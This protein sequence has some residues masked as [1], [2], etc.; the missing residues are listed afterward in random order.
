MLE[1]FLQVLNMPNT[2]VRF[3]G[4]VDITPN[5]ENKKVSRILMPRHHIPE[6][7]DAQRSEFRTQT[8]VN[9]KQHEALLSKN[10]V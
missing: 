9:G 5:T 2:K 6:N 3:Y 4:T 1:I 7:V 10:M 8:S